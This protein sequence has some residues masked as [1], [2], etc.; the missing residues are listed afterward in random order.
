M[1]LFVAADQ[2]GIERLKRWCRN[3]FRAKKHG[4]IRD[5][6]WFFMIFDDFSGFSMAFWC[7][8]WCFFWCLFVFVLGFPL[9]FVK[10][11]MQYSGRF[12]LLNLYVSQRF[13]GGEKH[14][15]IFKR[16]T[17]FTTELNWIDPSNCVATQFKNDDIQVLNGCWSYWMT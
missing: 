2:F 5:F 16:G 10:N 15:F 4:E 1:D 11:T 12:L 8:F 14:P 17:S 6:R 7:F 13:S 9:D 3:D